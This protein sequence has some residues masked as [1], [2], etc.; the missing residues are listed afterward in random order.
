MIYS[1]PFALP[2]LIP[3]GGGNPV[4]LQFYPVIY[5]VLHY[6]AVSC[7]GHATLKDVSNFAVSNLVLTFFLSLFSK[8]ITH[9]NHFPL[10]PLLRRC[11][12]LSEA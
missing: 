6:K 11:P 8:A 10:L 3:S 1:F 5:H 4:T 12:S 7:L 2:C 9:H